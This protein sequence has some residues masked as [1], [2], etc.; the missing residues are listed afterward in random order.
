VNFIKRKKL[1]VLTCAAVAL[2]AG[3]AFAYWTTTGSGTATARV[4]TSNGLAIHGTTSGSLYPGTSL[5]VTFT[6]DNSGSG[7]QQLGTIHL[8]SIVACDIAFS[9]GT[10]QSGHEITTCETT[11]AGASDTTT[12]DFWMPDVV[13][14]QEIA[15]GNGQSVTATG[16]LKLNDLSSNEDSCKNAYL[17]LNLTS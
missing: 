15:V 13:A 14:N 4:G 3:A 11:E 1:V 6:A 17:L 10:C 5:T 2:T 8:A 16:A 9:A 12:A 7:P